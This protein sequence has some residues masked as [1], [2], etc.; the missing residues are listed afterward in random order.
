MRL[1]I[2]ALLWV[3]VQPA[4]PP[5]ALPPP[6]P[7]AGA[8][9]ILDNDRVQVWNIAWLKGQPTALHRH[10]YD[11][12]GVYYEPGDRM[13]ISPEGAKRPVSTKAWDIA[14]Q[15]VGLTHIEEGTSDAPL[16]AIFTE[17]KKQ[18]PYATAAAAKDAPAF[19]GAGATQ[20]LDN[21]RVTVWEYIG[22]IAAARH[23]HL[24]D[25]VVVSIESPTPRATWIPQGTAHADEGAARASR[26]YLF[27]IK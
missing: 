20:K 9:K 1:I 15:R 11:L 3:V 17:M 22:P 23:T 16:R 24:R 26:V 27:E 4:A 25:T 18:E 13:I 7:R 10:I 14:F 2:A 6:Y 8:N 21:D 19:T 12:V 5:A